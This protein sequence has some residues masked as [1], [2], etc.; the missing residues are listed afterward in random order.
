MARPAHSSRSVCPL[1]PSGCRAAPGGSGRRAPRKTSSTLGSAVVRHHGGFSWVMQP[2]DCRFQHTQPI[3]C[4]S[5]F[6]WPPPS[7]VTARQT[8][9]LA[10]DRS[11]RLRRAVAGRVEGRACT[12]AARSPRRPSG[13]RCCRRRRA[14][15]RRCW[16]RRRPTGQLSRCR[17][18]DVGEERLDR[19]VERRRLLQVDGV[20]GAAG[21]S[22]ARRRGSPASASGSSPGTARPRRRAP[23]APASSSPRTRP[24]SRTATA[25]APGSAPS[26]WP[27]RAAECS[28][29]WSMNSCHARGLLRCSWMRVGAVADVV[30]HRRHAPRAE[31]LGDRRGDGRPRLALG[32]ARPR[33]GRR[34]DD[35]RSAR[36]GWRSANCSTA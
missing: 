23:A 13:H 31:A 21:G 22:T 16:P 12:P 11:C 14:P 34:G 33:P 6:P 29:R 7:P 24:G 30:G 4:M 26:C 5:T 20:A 32:R 8:T 19:R 36:S 18:L 17:S 3:G 15:R 1:R 9:A 2:F 25:A 27:S 10:P 28:R 35:A